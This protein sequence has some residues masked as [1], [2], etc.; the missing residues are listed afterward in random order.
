MTGDE[1]PKQKLR[2]STIPLL[3]R[4]TRSAPFSRAWL[5]CGRSPQVC[6]L[7]SQSFENEETRPDRDP[8]SEKLLS[9]SG[10]RRDG[11]QYESGKRRA[12]SR[13]RFAFGIL[14]V[15]AFADAAGAK[16]PNIGFREGESAFFRYARRGA[17]SKPA[18]QNITFLQ[19]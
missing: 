16:S 3:G 1:P 11:R 2:R 14:S 8:T 15:C 9:M 6:T 7:F 13:S 19:S 10:L 17:F 5:C 18:C 4:P 12:P